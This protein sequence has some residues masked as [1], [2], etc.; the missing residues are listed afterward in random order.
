MNKIAPVTPADQTV[1]DEE[2]FTR[3]LQQAVREAASGAIVI[4]GIVR[5]EDAYVRAE[6][7]V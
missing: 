6:G 5:F 2:A 7:G 4:P 1:T 3:A